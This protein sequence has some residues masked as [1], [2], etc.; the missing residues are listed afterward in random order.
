MEKKIPVVV[1]KDINDTDKILK[2]LNLNC[3]AL[4]TAN[5]YNSVGVYGN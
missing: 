5:I 2:A 3:R 1:I 4:G